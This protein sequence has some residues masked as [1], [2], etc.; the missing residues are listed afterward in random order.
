MPERHRDPSRRRAEDAQRQ[1][2]R[3]AEHRRRG[4]ADPRRRV[5]RSRR[6]GAGRDRRPRDPDRRCVVGVGRQGRR[7]H[8]ERRGRLEQA[9]AAGRAGEAVWQLPLPED[10]RK[11]LEAEVA[12]LRNIGTGGLRRLADGGPV[13]P[14]VRRRAPW[15]HLDIAG[16]SCSCPTTATAPRAAPASASAPPS[17]SPTRSPSPTGSRRHSASARVACAHDLTCYV[18]TSRARARGHDGRCRRRSPRHGSRRSAPVACLCTLVGRRGDVDR[19]PDRPGPARARLRASAHEPLVA[20]GGPDRH[21]RL[22]RPLR[23]CTQAVI[24]DDRPERMGDEHARVRS[25]P[26][27]PPQRVPTRARRRHRTG[28][29]PGPRCGAACP[30]PS[31]APARRRRRGRASAAR[32]SASSLARA[33]A[34]SV[35]SSS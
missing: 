6:G 30:R 33:S 2:R 9:R 35:S 10:L 13:P 29:R 3:G 11:L 20:E 1:D 16:P 28:A 7:P 23:M 24:R 25:L 27:L 14:G 21:E 18:R 17:S 32:P 22:D 34:R 26:R 31:A 12:D 8:G 15:A 4:A 5:S 19:P